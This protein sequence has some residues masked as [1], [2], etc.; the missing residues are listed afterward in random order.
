MISWEEING[1]EEVRLKPRIVGFVEFFEE[2]YKD[3][4]PKDQLF[5]AACMAVAL[6]LFG[7]LQEKEVRIYASIIHKRVSDYRSSIN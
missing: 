6:Y 7:P 4:L 5:N 2:R 1:S 3:E